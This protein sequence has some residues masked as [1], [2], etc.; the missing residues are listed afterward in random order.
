[1]SLPL[2]FPALL[3]R[4]TCFCDRHPLNIPKVWGLGCTPSLRGA[5]LGCRT[6]DSENTPGR[7]RL[8]SSVGF[9]DLR[10]VKHRP[11]Q[12]ARA[13]SAGHVLWV[14]LPG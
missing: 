12:E 2:A 11:Q 6:P 13:F 4:R 14:L 5:R 10:R 7:A 3:S 8:S 1:M 9:V